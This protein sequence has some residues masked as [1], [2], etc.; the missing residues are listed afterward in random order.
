LHFGHRFRLFVSKIL[1]QAALEKRLAIIGAGSAQHCR[2]LS[3]AFAAILA[4][5]Y[6]A[7]CRKLK[8]FRMAKI[9]IKRKKALWQDRARQYNILVDGRE[10]AS[11]ASG[12]A[13]E[14]EV[15]PGKH[16]VQMK[17][18]WCNSQ[19]FDV[20]VGA[21]QTVTL[22]CGPNASPFLALFYITLWKDKYIWLRGAGAI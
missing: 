7:W 14:I 8:E 11:V 17:I 18:D 20:D 6:P 13:V 16:V 1:A 10:V 4:T 9:I 12:A 5:C 21:E 3:A 2:A 15:E 22:E 19:K